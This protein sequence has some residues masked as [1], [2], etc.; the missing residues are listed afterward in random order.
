MIDIILLIILTL[1]FIT[2]IIILETGKDD[3]DQQHA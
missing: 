3:N 1:G 2:L